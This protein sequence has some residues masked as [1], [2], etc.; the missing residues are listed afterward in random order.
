MP[1]LFRSCLRPSIPKRFLYAKAKLNTALHG[2]SLLDK[3][4]YLVL[5]PFV[6]PFGYVNNFHRRLRQE[7]RVQWFLKSAVELFIRATKR[8][9]AHLCLRDALDVTVQTTVVTTGAETI[10]KATGP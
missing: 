10:I 2:S 3:S 6:S 9:R 7:S 1:L 8:M 4:S 5:L